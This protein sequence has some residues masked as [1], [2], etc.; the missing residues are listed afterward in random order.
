MTFCKLPPLS[1]SYKKIMQRLAVIIPAY[2]RT[3]FRKALES[4]SN[5][6]NKNFSVYIGN[7]CSPFELD[8]IVADFV[9]KI[10]IFY[11]KFDENIGSKNLVKQWER[12]VQLAK[13]E[14]WLWLFSDDDL[15]DANGVENF[16]SIIE[17]NGNKFDVYR[18]NT[19]VIDE[20]DGIVCYTTASPAEESSEDMAYNLLLGKRGNSMP[21]HIFSRE[22]FQKRGG[23]V[24]TKFAQAADWATSINFSQTKGIAVIPD[25]HLYWRVSGSNI[26]SIASGNTQKMLHGHIQFIKW[27]VSHFL[28]LK[29]DTKSSVTYDMILFAARINLRTVIINHYKGISNEDLYDFAHVCMH[30]LQLSLKEVISDL[31]MIKRA[32]SSRINIPVNFLKSIIG[33]K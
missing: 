29:K 22:I 33:N 19:C 32:T 17:K 12:C 16:Y 1:H 26:S 13:D 23:F 28:Y 2:K 24:F 31:Y 4:L 10:D 3:Y 14:E 25:S 20:N 9:D 7:D 8:D 18:F 21:D 6:T 30:Y 15:V 5:Q 11:H 27:L